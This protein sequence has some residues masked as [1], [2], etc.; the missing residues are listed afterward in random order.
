MAVFTPVSEQDLARWLDERFRLGALLR[1]EAIAQGV[2]NT[3]YFVDTVGAR[4]VLTLAERVPEHAIGFYLSLMKHLAGRGIRCPE[5]IE[6][7]DGALWGRLAG[8]PAMLATRLAGSQ[9][10]QAEVAD[11]HAVGA[12]LA[13]MH[14]AAASFD[15]PAPPNPRGLAWWIEAARELAPRMPASH[16]ALMRDELAFQQ[17]FAARTSAPATSAARVLPRSAVHADLF[18]DNVLFDTDGVPGAIDF[19]FACDDW[20]IFDLAVTCNDWCLAAD[21]SDTVFES[22]RLHAL[23]SGYESRRPL[24]E[25]ERDAWPAML[26][27]AA[28]RFWMS[29]LHDLLLPRDASLLAPKDPAGFRRILQAHRNAAPP[30]PQ[31]PLGRGP[32]TSA[33]A[34][35]L[36]NPGRKARCR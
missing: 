13:D 33:G 34:S 28:F 27:A 32:G 26:R 18:R 20:W 15:M 1:I 7:V 23:I 19:W 5:P 11:C 29:R 9:R 30:L 3:N 35:A 22:T 17:A 16:V 14:L 36:T 8:K 4:F 12:L 6:A 21:G 25:A 24:R 10:M 2:E 31:G